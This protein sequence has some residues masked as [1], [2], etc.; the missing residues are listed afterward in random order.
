MNW[1]LPEATTTLEEAI[2]FLKRDG[3]QEEEAAV[4]AAVNAAALWIERHTARRLASR[5]YRDPATVAGCTLTLDSKAVTGTGF[6]AA[7]K[8]HDAVVG[9]GIAPGSRVESVDSNTALTLSHGATA[10]AVG[11]ASLTFG[12]E[13]LVQ[14]GSGKRTLYALEQPLVDLYA[15]RWIGADNVETAVDLTGYRIDP[16]A[17]LILLAYDVF[18]RGQANIEL[19]C[20]A[21]YRAA[22]ATDRGH[23]EWAVLQW[24]CHRL[25]A[26][27]FRDQA[28]ALGR[29]VSQQLGAMS[30][31]VPD[32]DPPRDVVSALVPYRRLG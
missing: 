26:C 11:N 28:D 25:A 14:D 10:A 20:R 16:E 12:S 30:T 22:T 27:L 3:I 29:A 9:I 6:T 18:P 8:P 21:G 7:V 32:F 23:P 13:P 15:A 1:L 31:S 24:A 2:A 5:T 19:D 17:G 4:A